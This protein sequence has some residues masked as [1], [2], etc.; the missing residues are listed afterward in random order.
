MRP[1]PLNNI[2]R[3]RNLPSTPVLCRIAAVLEVTVDTLLKSPENAVAYVREAPAG[4]ATGSPP[5]QDLPVA[6]IARL[7]DAITDLPPTLLRQ[8]DA[9]TAAYLALEDLCNAPKRAVIPLHLPFEPTEFGMDRLAA[10]VRQLMGAGQAVVFDYLELFEN[11][12]LRV[13]FMPLTRGWDSL[14]GFDAANANAFFFIAVRRNPEKQLFRLAY[15]LGRIYLHTRRRYGG[16]LEPE[17][18]N[19]TV[20]MLDAEHAA[21]RFAACFLMPEEAVRTSVGQVAVRPGDWDEA[22]LL[23]LKHRFGVSAEAFCIRLEELKL[24]DPEVAARL[25]AD[26]RAGYARTGFAEPGE[27]RRILS[28]NGRLGDLLLSAVHHAK[29]PDAAEELATLR[30]TLAE[31][32]VEML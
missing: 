8:V 2:E 22:L 5:V 15:E 18:S 14:S 25:K 27:S 3:G 26:I 24:I 7:P 23:R 29:D 6:E 19:A 28:P 20:G 21:R 4:Y 11:L 31:H 13:V 30:Q 9:L 32:Q 1:Q 17:P 16:G 10:R 12:G